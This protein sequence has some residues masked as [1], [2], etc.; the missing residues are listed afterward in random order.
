M[1]TTSDNISPHPD[2]PKGNL[3][4]KIIAISLAS[5]V[6]LVIV[7]LS[8]ISL[9]LTSER[10]TSLVNKKA[11]QYL[12]ADIHATNISYTLWSSFPRFRITTDSIVVRSHSL[13]SVSPAV[14][15]TLPPNSD[16]LGSLKSF[17]GSINI[18]DLFLNRYVIHDVEIDGLNINLVAYNDS[19]NNYNLIPASGEKLKNIPYFSADLVKLKNTGSLRYFSKASDTEASLQLSDLTLKRFEDSFK[20]NEYRL[21]I[22]G[23]VTARSAGISILHKFPFSLDG[24]LT[25][26]FDPFGVSLSDYGID[27][28]EIHSKLSMS[29]GMGDDPRIES[30]DYRISSVNLMNLLGYIPQ[31]YIPSLQGLQADMPISASARLISAW[32]LSNEV[33]PSVEVQFNV[34]QGEIDYTV[35]TSASKGTGDLRTYHL[36]HSPIKGI[37]VFD[38]THPDKSYLEIPGFSLFASGVSADIE[39][40]VTQ[41]TGE[42]LITA[43]LGVEA[44]IAQALDL[45]P[46]PN[47]VKAS[48]QLKSNTAVSFR[49][50]SF[51]REAISQGLLDIRIT[52]DL[53]INNL[54]MQYPAENMTVK[55]N[56][57]TAVIEE[58]AASLTPNSISYPLSDVRIAI[59]HATAGSSFGRFDV[60]NL[61]LST[62]AATSKSL[63]PENLRQGLPLK[64]DLKAA[65]ASFIDSGA[66]LMAKASQLNVK[67]II[68]T[69]SPQS[70]KEALSDGLGVSA[71]AVSIKSDNSEFILREPSLNFSISERNRN[72]LDSLPKI[73]ASAN[74]VPPSKN[75]PVNVSGQ[76]AHSPE[77]LAFT[78]PPTVKDLL[79]T[80]RFSTDLKVKRIDINSPGFRRGDY[81]ADMD[82]S[83]DEEAL[84]LR[85][86]ALRLSNTPASLRGEISNLKGFLTSPPSAD[87]PLMINLFADIDKININALTGSYV[88]AQGGEKAVKSRPTSL[89]SDTVAMLIPRNIRADIKASIGEAL[90]TNLNLTDVAA[91]IHVAD[92]NVDINRIALTTS[93]AKAEAGVRYNTAD[94]DDMSLSADLNIKRIDIVKF[95]DKF[96]SISRMMPQIKNLSGDISIAGSLASDIFPT[97]NLN[98]PSVQADLSVGGKNLTVHQNH[99]IRR[100]TRMLMIRTDKDIHIKDMT[101]RAAMHDNLLQLYP[102]DFEFDRYK[103]HML[104]V[105]NFNGKLYYHIGVEESPLHFPF[106]I[107]IEGMFH[108]PRLRFG[109]PRFDLRKAEAVTTEIQESNSINLMHVM[110]SLMTTFVVTGAK[111]ENYVP[112]DSGSLS[113]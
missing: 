4:I 51:S 95:I 21:A 63:T 106:S 112:A 73:L 111:Y 23:D 44:E 13:D 66:T 93:F 45:I 39:A 58:N 6:G 67:D 62:V 85:N 71:S 35:S 41:L 18:I 32:N 20:K 56:R 96:P 57:L 78:L 64:F 104:G 90:Y 15:K 74:I 76:P 52:G 98:I 80:F 26:R 101:V 1:Y 70:F 109:G 97:M 89:P 92:G 86:L 108:H 107:N 65:D 10:L 102:F 110:R 79:N 77:L 68:S 61:N 94:I 12:N 103:L 24:N 82:L 37:F 54:A 38:G 72:V 91:D 48:G 19:I 17:K 105:N 87:N 33:F 55:V 28:G 83:F 34:P 113:K 22:D 3:I 47:P 11:G 53:E 31:E 43:N 40:K 29:V 88:A 60:K 50:G 99:F 49:I 100:I 46:V 69:F 42:P 30:F 27:L 7:L 8:G 2:K 9:F 84:T 16:F 75:Q 59:D 5:V 81:L 25:L 14:L 36:E